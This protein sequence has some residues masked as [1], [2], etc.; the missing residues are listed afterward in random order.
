[1][2]K[3]P[4]LFCRNTD[5]DNKVRDEVVSGCEWVQAG[6]GVATVKHDG[7]CCMVRSGQLFK[8]YELKPG[9]HM[10]AAFERAQDPDPITGRT[11]GWLPVGDGPEDQWH[12]EAWEHPMAG[13]ARKPLP[14]GTYE[15]CGP[16]V[17]GNPE[18]LSAHFLI[19]HGAVAAFPPTHF[20]SLREYLAERNIEGV[21][22]H[23]PDGRMA[24]IKKRDFGL[25]RKP[26]P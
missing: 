9:Q 1:M 5:G 12:R 4:T 21:V 24:K 26:Q 15:L 8:R 7:T 3:I 19:R 10:P 22:W 2:K 17:Q 25:P 11:P 16:K 14:D 13:N 18:G 20:V 23:H 6:E